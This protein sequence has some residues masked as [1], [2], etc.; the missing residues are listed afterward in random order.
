MNR[1]IALVV[2][3]LLIAGCK[4]RHEEPGSSAGPAGSS[5]GA[6]PQAGGTAGQG[7]RPTASSSPTAQAGP[8]KDT[9]S[10][11]EQ[12]LSQDIR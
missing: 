8:Q 9:V 5:Q 11:L 7:N 10:R 6:Q 3:V 1:V 2:I 12:E 4:S